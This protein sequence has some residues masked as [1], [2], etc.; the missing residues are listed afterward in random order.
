MAL[1][2]LPCHKPRIPMLPDLLLQ[3]GCDCRVMAAGMI[4]AA[5]CSMMSS[6]LRL[7][8]LRTHAAPTASC[9]TRPGF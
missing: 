4:G 7:S 1:L 9:S 5:H 6:S 2:M 3:S 8:F